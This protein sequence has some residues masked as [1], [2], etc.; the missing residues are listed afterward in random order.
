MNI[1]FSGR[2]AKGGE[3]RS[4]RCCFRWGESGECRCP[5]ERCRGGGGEAPGRDKDHGRDQRGADR[6]GGEAEA[7]AQVEEDAAGDRAAGGGGQGAGAGAGA[8]GEGG[9]QAADSGRDSQSGRIDGL[10]LFVFLDFES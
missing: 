7:G 2:E 4:P 8:A 10:V 5:K 6:G 1:S 3:E 9:P